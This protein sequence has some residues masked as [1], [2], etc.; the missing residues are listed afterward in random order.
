MVSSLFLHNTAVAGNWIKERYRKDRSLGFVLTVDEFTNM[1]LVRFLK[2]NQDN[3]VVWKNNG[4]YV[5]IEN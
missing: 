1:M 4:H 2:I 3:W 5:V